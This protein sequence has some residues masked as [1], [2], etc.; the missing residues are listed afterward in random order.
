MNFHDASPTEGSGSGSG[1]LVRPPTRAGG[2]VLYEYA[3]LPSTNDLAGTLPVWSAVRAARQKAGRGRYQRS[4]ISDVGGLWISAVVPVGAP[5]SGWGALPLAAGLAVCEA[6]TAW[7]AGP[8]RLRW[9]NDV[10]VGERKLAGL[11]VDQFR[12]GA[13]V[14]GIGVN[15]SNRPEA[16]D[17][18]LAGAVVRLEELV[19]LTPSLEALSMGILDRLRGVVET[20]Q[21]EGFAGLVPRVNAWWR[22]GMKVEIESGEGRTE[23]VFLGVDSTGRLRVGNPAG[24]TRDL[25]AHQVVRMRELPGDWS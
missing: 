15:V 9:P 11:L 7:R 24:E 16:E 18:A 10:M 21:A 13:A 6:L 17:P 19:T 2:W 25:A 12:P 3:E 23:G 22:T 1:D 20:M 4:W 5:E 14:V 8:L